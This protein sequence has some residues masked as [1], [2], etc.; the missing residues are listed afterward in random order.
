MAA[1]VSSIQKDWLSTITN[2]IRQDK[3]SHSSARQAGF[4]RSADEVTSGDFLTAVPLALPFQPG[5]PHQGE[6]IA[7]GKKEQLA[8][9]VAL[10][11]L[12]EGAGNF[13]RRESVPAK[14]QLHQ[15]FLHNIEVVALQ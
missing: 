7:D 9:G 2:K 5:Q 15:D 1:Q 13:Q 4:D 6:E 10:L 3:A 11:P 8:L 14:D 12:V